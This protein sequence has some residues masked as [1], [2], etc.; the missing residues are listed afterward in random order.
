MSRNNPT[1]PK[2]F[3][4][5]IAAL[6]TSQKNFDFYG[7]WCAEA[8][9]SSAIVDGN[10]DAFA[11][12]WRTLGNNTRRNQ[13]V[14]WA[15]EMSGGVVNFKVQKNELKS[16]TKST[17]DGTQ[18]I[19]DGLLHRDEAGELVLDDEGKAGLCPQFVEKIQADENHVFRYK[20]PKAEGTKK[21]YADELKTAMA[22]VLKRYGNTDKL[23]PARVEDAEFMASLR[24]KFNGIFSDLP[25]PATPASE[26]S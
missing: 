26:T 18:E 17:R 8:A 19:I 20:Q 15:A 6:V 2:N 23:E 21:F 12:V 24:E 25:V 11:Q 1:I 16:V 3:A 9:M 5:G 14:V 13:L 10:Y 4:A 7:Q 22:R